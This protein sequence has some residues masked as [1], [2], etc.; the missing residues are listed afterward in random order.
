MTRPGGSESFATIGALSTGSLALDAA[1]G[2]GG[3]PRGRIVEIYGPAASGKTTLALH[4]IAEAQKAGGV[5]AFIDAEHA[6][7]AAYAR[8]LGVNLE[9]LLVS[10]PD[11]GEQA[12]D[13]IEVLV[14][15]GALDA[16][17][18]DSVAALV[19]KAELDGA[20]GEMPLGMQARLV[21]RGLRKLTT[22]IN[23]SRTSL[24]FLNQLRQKLGVTLG[25]PETTTGGNA[26]QFHASVCLD[27]RRINT[28]TS[29][30]DAL[31]GRTRVRVVK[32]KLAPPFRQ[33]EFDIVYGEGISRPGE[34][35]DL[36]VEQ[37]LIIQNDT[38]FSYR[39]TY[40]GQGRED[41]KAFLQTFSNTVANLETR[42]RQHLGL[43]TSLAPKE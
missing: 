24:I 19:P 16:I 33:V 28:L 3:I 7:D 11:T 36:A 20:M 43:S 8:N 32:N 35:L 30:G 40:I 1:L 31:G 42:V 27:I 26:L 18:V 9:T 38:G 2:I 13:I 5:T 4:I 25:H 14:R 10:Q 37:G 15:S 39:D 29:G 41:A 21:S 34:L 17:V 6:L 22:I 12:L 23:K